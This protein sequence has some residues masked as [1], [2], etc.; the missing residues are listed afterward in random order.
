MSAGVTLRARAGAALRGRTRRSLVVAE[1][2]PRR[3]RLV[4]WGGRWS[5]FLIEACAGLG[6]AEGG[7][8]LG[9]EAVARAIG[10]L[11]ELIEGALAR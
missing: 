1:G 9:G 2:A 4:G 10:R 11:R 8:R 6:V 3:V 5:G 7:A